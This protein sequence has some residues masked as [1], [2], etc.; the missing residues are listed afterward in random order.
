MNIFDKTTFQKK[1]SNLNTPSWLTSL[2]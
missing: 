1:P 2:V